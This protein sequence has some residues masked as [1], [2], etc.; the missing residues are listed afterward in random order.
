LLKHEDATSHESN[1]SQEQQQHPPGGMIDSDF[2]H[3]PVQEL[4][5]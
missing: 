5:I 4:S 2:F 3:K 1:T